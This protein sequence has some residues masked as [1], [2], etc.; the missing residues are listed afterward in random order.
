MSLLILIIALSAG[1]WAHFNHKLPPSVQEWTDQL[2]R[3]VERGVKQLREEPLTVPTIQVP[4]LPG[5][6]LVAPTA[7]A[8]ATPTSVSDTDPTDYA[9]AE[10][11]VAQRIN[12]F[13]ASRGLSS[14][15]FSG[16]LSAVAR[17]HS[18][19]MANRS[20][21]DHVNPD[22]LEPQ[23]RVESAGLIDFSCS[24]NLYQVIN[25]TLDDADHI[26]LEAFTGWL[27]SPGHYE[28][29]IGP[30]HDTGG[31]GVF[32][33]SR[34]LLGDL[35]PRRYDIYVTHLLCKNISEYNQLQVQY[36]DAYSLYTEYQASYELLLAAY[37]SVEDRYVKNEVPRVNL[38]AAYDE[39]ESTVQLLTAQV[40][41]VNNLVERLNLA[42]AS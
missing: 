42:A 12:E 14:L 8:E 22:G 26:A 35:T 29:M 21:F 31:V 38:D 23:G 7:T 10:A 20:F 18:E 2:H 37:R 17:T 13:R 4:S 27:H 19:D 6:L 16:A 33:Q 39:L 28:N 15:T 32:I 36:E 11:L 9:E 25:A 1:T 41:I 3:T 40:E 34:L 30:S 5:I 24:E